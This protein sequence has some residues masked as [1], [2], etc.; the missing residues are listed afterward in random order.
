MI[1]PGTID[2]PVMT[3]VKTALGQQKGQD[4]SITSD[5]VML[6][7]NLILRLGIRDDMH[8]DETSVHLASVVS[9]LRRKKGALITWEPVE[10][11]AP[12]PGALRPAPSC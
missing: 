8:M 10:P 6:A 2:C 12:T 4:A 9:G 11:D 7:S 5:Q 1:K 3:Q